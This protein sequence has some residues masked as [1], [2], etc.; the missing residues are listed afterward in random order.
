MLETQVPQQHQIILSLYLST[1]H[2]QS[3]FKDMLT[4]IFKP[5]CSKGDKYI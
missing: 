4:Y 2:A 5:H 1:A 3:V